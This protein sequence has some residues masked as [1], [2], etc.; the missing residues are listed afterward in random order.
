MPRYD[1]LQLVRLPERLERRKPGGGGPPPPRDLA[2]HTTKLR[3]ELDAAV[4]TQ[5]RRRKP[6][7]VDP[8]LI[9]RVQMT[10]ALLEEQWE[11]LGLTVLS[12]DADRTLILFASN[13][14][15]RDFRARLDAY[16]GGAPAG[17]KA[18]PYN[19][20]IGTIETIGAVEPRDRIGVRLREDGFVEPADFQPRTTYLVD[21]ELWD[22]GDRRLRERKL[23]QIVAYIEARDG[24]VLDQYIGPSITMARVRLQGKLL[25]TLLTIEDIASI[26]QPPQPDVTT[27][28]AY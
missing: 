20:F 7:F 3:T 17:Q 15:M 11:Q 10:G 26:D 6:E 27:P 1:H 24:E 23:G 14:D 18:A 25:L 16:Q 22:L 2:V 21:L 13:D 8:S 5:R 4:E 28:A 9:L 19:A 12:S